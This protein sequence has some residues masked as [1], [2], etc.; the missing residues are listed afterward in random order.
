MITQ[1]SN[2]LA[3]IRRGIEGISIRLEYPSTTWSER[4]KLR[5]GET[6]CVMGSAKALQSTN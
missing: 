3:V 4:P 2:L 6:S 5:L 1:E